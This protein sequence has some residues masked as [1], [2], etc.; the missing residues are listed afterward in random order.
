MPSDLSVIALNCTLKSARDKE[1]SS[2][3]ILLEQIL[4][5]FARRGC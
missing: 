2:T 3:Q 4:E 1:Q 5:A